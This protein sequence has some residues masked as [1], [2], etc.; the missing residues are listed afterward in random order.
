MFL[1]TGREQAGASHDDGRQAG[2]S[3]DDGG[4]NLVRMATETL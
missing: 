1:S 4:E 2:A 3:H